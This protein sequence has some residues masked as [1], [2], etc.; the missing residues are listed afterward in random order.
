ML[1]VNV[2]LF[3]AWVT[4]HDRPERVDFPTPPFAD[5]TAITFPTS[6][7]LRRWG[8]PRC[9]RASCGG[10]PE[11]GKPLAK[12]NK[13]GLWCTQFMLTSGFSCC[14]CHKIENR[15]ADMMLDSHVHMAIFGN[16]YD[17]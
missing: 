7:I 3:S 2:I 16:I 9:I 6:F 8:K 14:R 17:T 1:S 10:A 5:D 4:E 13:R 15:R 12:V 11:R